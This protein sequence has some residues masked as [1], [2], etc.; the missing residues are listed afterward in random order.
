M[1]SALSWREPHVRLLE[2]FGKRA[3]LSAHLQQLRER[4][5]EF[6]C[7]LRARGLG[8]GERIAC[9]VDVE[10]RGLALAEASLAQAQVLARGGERGLEQPELL[11]CLLDLAIRRFDLREDLVQRLAAD[12][13]DLA[14]RLAGRAHLVAAVLAR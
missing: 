4:D 6:V 9:L 5:H 8:A 1:F 13:I 11:A 7:G 14:K 3:G 10:A 2:E 12:R